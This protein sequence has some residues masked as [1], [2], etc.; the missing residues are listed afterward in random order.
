M[1]SSRFS[2][3]E[4][5]LGDKIRMCLTIHTPKMSHGEATISINRPTDTFRC[6][7]TRQELQELYILLA[8]VH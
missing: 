7:L 5:E 3:F 4:N 8:E 6:T 1:G 2:Q